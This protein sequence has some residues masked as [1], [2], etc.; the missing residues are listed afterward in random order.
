MRRSWIEMSK[1]RTVVCGENTGDGGDV[2]LGKE[3]TFIL[4]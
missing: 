4:S 1:N 2:T 3:I